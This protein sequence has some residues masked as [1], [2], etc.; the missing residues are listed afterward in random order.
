M[1]Q[2]IPAGAIYVAYSSITGDAPN[3]RSEILLT[4][5]MDCGNTWS[6]PIKVSRPEDAINQGS[7]LTIDPRTGAVYVGW[8]R[9]DPDLT[10][11]NDLDGVMVARLPFG[12]TRVDT[13]N[14]AYKFPKP[15]RKV[16]RQLHRLFEHRE[17]RFKNVKVNEATENLDQFDLGTTGY[18]FR[19]NAYPTMAADGSGRVYIAWT[20]RGFAANPTIDSTGQVVS[21]G[22]ADGARIVIATTRDGRNFTTPVPVDDH[23]TPGRGHQLMPSMA[24]AG[25]KLMLVFYD[26]RDSKA[27]THNRISS[28]YNTNTGLRQTI[29]IRSAMA[30]PGD[31]PAFAP[32]VKVSDYLMGFNPESGE[33]EELQVNPPNLPMFKQGTVPFI[34][35]YIDVTAAPAFI[36]AK[37]GKWEYNT[38]N[39]GEIRCSTRRGPTIAMS[40]RRR[41]ASGG[42]TRRR[43]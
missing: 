35:D 39:T 22:L 28:D 9:F 15:T 3:L 17:N 37:N 10:D 43:R 19:T 26:L 6:A 11:T 27:N 30:T 5:S 24:F 12:A 40:G 16:G 36:P 21:S 8:R 1:V 33:V 20:Q 2:R 42:T 34:G 25:G 29:D 14:R 18:N 32:S 13:P 41:T 38:A 23:D 31:H 4:R 7:S